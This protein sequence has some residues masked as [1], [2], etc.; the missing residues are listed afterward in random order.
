MKLYTLVVH[1]LQ[2][3]VKLN[4]NC[5]PINDV[6]HHMCLRQNGFCQLC[7]S[8]D[9]ETTHHF[10][11]EC[12]D[13]ERVNFFFEITDTQSSIDLLIDVIGLPS[14]NKIQLLIGDHGFY[15]NE[16]IDNIL[17]TKVKKYLKNL[18]PVRDQYILNS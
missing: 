14:I 12:Q 2:M 13:F 16:N 3:C 5:L 7:D 10:M 1:Y 4:I 9:I 11:L 8:I 6:L 15:F 17:D 18:V